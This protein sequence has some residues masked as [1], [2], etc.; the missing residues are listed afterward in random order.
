MGSLRGLAHA[1]ARGDNRAVIIAFDM[2]APQLRIAE[3]IGF[4][5]QAPV[6]DEPSA[7]PT[8][9]ARFQ[10]A[11]LGQLLRRDRPAHRTY[12]PEIAWIDGGQIR[13]ET[14][15]GRLPT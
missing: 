5:S 15:D 10:N 8:L 14:Y 1:G 3:R 2:D 9:K 4:C 7:P 11:S 12:T 6:L 13:F